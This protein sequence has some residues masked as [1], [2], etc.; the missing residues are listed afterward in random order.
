M[1]PIPGTSLVEHLENVVA[2]DL[3]LTDK[4]VTTLNG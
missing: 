3:R 1:L 4:E 2:T